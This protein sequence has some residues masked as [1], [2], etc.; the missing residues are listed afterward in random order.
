M[1]RLFIT[2]VIHFL[3]LFTLIVYLCSCSKDCDE[4]TYKNMKDNGLYKITYPY[5]ET[6]TD[7]NGVVV[8]KKTYY[9][10][11]QLCKAYKCP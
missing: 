9:T 6:F 7:N 5:T 2:L 10:P 1:K 4:C 11:K 8:I 3:F